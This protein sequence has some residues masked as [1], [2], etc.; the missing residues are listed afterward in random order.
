MVIHTDRNNV[1]SYA[2]AMESDGV[3]PES[4]WRSQVVSWSHLILWVA[5]CRNVACVREKA[6]SQ[7][8]SDRIDTTGKLKCT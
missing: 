2:R 5:P 8:S 6:Y 1:C 4:K 3:V 7:Q